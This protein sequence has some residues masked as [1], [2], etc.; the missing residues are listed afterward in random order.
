MKFA[1]VLFVC[2]TVA[3]LASGPARA[4]PVAQLGESCHLPGWE[5]ALR[6]VRVPVTLD[7]ATPAA[8][9]LPLMVVVAP[10]F[11]QAAR[12]D[13]LF[14]LAGGPG[15]AG[16]DVLP[17]L[18]MAFLKVRATRDIVFID[19]R[20][21]GKSGKLDCDSTPGQDSLPDDAVM[22]QLRDCLGRI[23]QP[24]AAY[25]TAAAARDLEQ[26]RL[27]LG[28]GK[29]NVWG[30]SYGTRLGQAYARAYPD[31]VRSLILDGV[32]AP[33]QI[34][35][36]GGHDGQV[37]LDG[38]F[39]A[40]AADAACA[41]AYPALKSEFATVLQRVAAG[42]AVVNTTDPRTAAPLRLT[43]SS[44]RFL[45]TVHSMLYAPLDSRRLPFLIHSA[46]GGRWEPF[47]ARSNVASDFSADGEV[48]F[49]LHLAV[50]CAEDMPRLT[51]AL[52]DSDVKDSFLAA[53]QIRRLSN[54]CDVIKVPPVPYAKP[55]TIAAPA[56][57]LSGA[58]DPVTPPH[59]AATAAQAMRHAQQFVVA[60]AGHGISTLGCAPRLLRAFL[61]QPEQPLQA[62]C[63][64]EIPA[65]SFQLGNAGPQP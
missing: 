22:A 19:Q 55:A 42:D 28:Y 48:A 52:L 35:P 56:L 44:N 9:P 7:P 49:G 17:L 4:V 46:Y 65:A 27:A 43:I 64:G 3:G 36:A 10:A 24:F 61:D 23:K 8:K 21:T 37:A 2:L 1:A 25:T 29:V 57:L 12:T 54:L 41:K 20:G 45:G 63:L 50:I 6:C 39:A 53:P 31:S 60:N 58:L 47:L 16:S 5:E 13:P 15:Q 33:D 59:R 32:A 62:Q 38:L 14:V 40:C 30:G 34:I 18:N 26:V 51:P 11:R